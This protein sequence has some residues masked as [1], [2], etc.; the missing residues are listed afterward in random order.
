MSGNLSSL[1]DDLWTFSHLLDAFMQSDLL[2]N[3]NNQGNSAKRELSASQSEG[4]FFK[5]LIQ[6]LL[7]NVT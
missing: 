2:K 6:L 3:G 7:I 4:Y 5:S 1:Q